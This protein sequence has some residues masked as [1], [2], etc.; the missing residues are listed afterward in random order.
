MGR[1]CPHQTKGSGN[2][3][4]SASDYGA[5][6]VQ[7]FKFIAVNAAPST[8]AAPCRALNPALHVVSETG[9]GDN[10]QTS[11]SELNT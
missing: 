3:V 11:D 8:S 4:S 10:R 2:V 6:P 5:E 1:V 7:C 9:L